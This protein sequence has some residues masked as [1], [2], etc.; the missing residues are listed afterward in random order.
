[1]INH[2]IHSEEKEV[3]SA[4]SGM[5]VDMLNM[6]RFNILIFK[7]NGKW[8]IY[9]LTRKYKIRTDL[10]IRWKNCRKTTTR[11]KT[12]NP[13]SAKLSNSKYIYIFL[14]KHIKI[15]TN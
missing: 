8:S 11:W 12:T 6:R 4:K 13:N 7:Y 1:M 2:F 5:L 15:D 10:K 14:D 9:Y 3:L